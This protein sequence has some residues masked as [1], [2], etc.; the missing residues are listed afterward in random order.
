MRNK[1][2]IN[3]SAVLMQDCLYVLQEIEDIENQH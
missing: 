1:F 3:K 2:L